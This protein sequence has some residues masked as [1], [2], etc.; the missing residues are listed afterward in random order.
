MVDY[1]PSEITIVIGF[2]ISS[3]H[4]TVLVSMQYSDLCSTS[5]SMQHNQLSLF[6]CPL[7]IVEGG[8]CYD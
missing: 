8:D 4:S 1:D 5:V 2:T 3:C 7:F 6:K